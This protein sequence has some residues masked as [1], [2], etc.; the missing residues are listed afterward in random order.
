MHAD[1]FIA[2]T[3]VSSLSKRPDDQGETSKKA[4]AFSRRLSNSGNLIKAYILLIVKPLQ[5]VG[6]SCLHLTKRHYQ[7]YSITTAGCHHSGDL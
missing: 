1:T 5:K 2:A 6:E 4:A 7:V 3:T